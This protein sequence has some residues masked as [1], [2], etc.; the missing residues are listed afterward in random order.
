[1]ID[2]IAQVLAPLP[3]AFYP[4]SLSFFQLSIIIGLFQKK[5]LAG[6]G[7]QGFE[8]MEFPGVSKNDQKWPGKNNVEFP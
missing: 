2:E 6:S 7:A 8:D 5:K 3:L 4:F 1:M